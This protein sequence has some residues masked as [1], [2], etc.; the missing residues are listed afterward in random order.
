MIDNFSKQQHRHQHGVRRMWFGIGGALAC[1]YAWW[2]FYYYIVAQKEKEKKRPG[3]ME[4]PEGFSDDYIHPYHSKPWIIK[5]LVV[6]KR[7]LV[8]TVYFAPFLALSVLMVL[9]QHSEGSTIRGLWLDFLVRGCEMCG[10]SFQK[11][12]QW[13]SMR[14]DMMPPDVIG[15]LSKLRHDAPV[16]S[17][18]T[19]R[20]VLQEA[21]GQH[22]D[23]QDVFERFDAEPVA[24]GSGKTQPKVSLP[25]FTAYTFSPNKELITNTK[26]KTHTETQRF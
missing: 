8:V 12:G 25:T 21:L 10:C 11:F 3:I 18:S 7:L 23:V 16:H 15:A 2:G 9:F 14:P 4:A 24:S 17:I 6:T 26:H 5:A 22:V 19:T 1:A 20:R 13:M